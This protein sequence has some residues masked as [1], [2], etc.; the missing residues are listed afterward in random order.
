MADILVL[1]ER[2]KNSIQLG[3]SHIREFKSAWQGRPDDKKK[4]DVK[5]LCWYIGEALVAFANADGGVL[6]IGVEDDGVITG[7]PHTEAE[8][9]CFLN[10]TKTH[11]HKDTPIP[12]SNA[13]KVEIDGKKVLFFSVSKGTTTVCQLPDGRCVQRN[14]KATIPASF[15]QITFERQE[16]K[17][18]NYDRE[19]IDGATVNDLDLSLLQPIASSYIK[20]IS[21][22]RYLQQIGLAE[23]GENLRLRMAA[24]L[25]FAK[26]VQKWHPR[27][28]IRILRISGTELKSGT[29]YNV[30]SDETVLGNIFQLIE[31]SWERLRP[32]LASKVIFD[33]E[34]KFEQ[35]FIYPEDACKEALINAITHRDYSIQNGIDI[36]IFTDRIEIKNPGAL[37]SNLTIKG[38]EELQGLHESRNV[39]I[40]MVLRENKY[41][42]ELGEGMKRMFTLMQQSELQKPKLYSNTTW[43]SITFYRK[44]SFSQVEEQ[45]LSIFDSYNLTP[46]Q[47][48]LVVLGIKGREICPSE[49]FKVLGTEDLLIYGEEVKIL[50]NAGIF[51]EIRTNPQALQY[52]KRN[53]IPKRQVPRFKVRIPKGN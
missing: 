18:R 26:N 17:S 23:Y 39:Y 30:I 19:F 53:K 13:A 25:L 38:L 41:V 4:G 47:K 12:L 34:A 48:R 14:D 1:Q 24:L 51:E 49:I 7:I 29:E 20:G 10:A 44:S 21:I 52:S 31:N 9:E 27:S 35:K 40:A 46:N 11:I 37:L 5:A 15:S 8:I 42:R 33:E 36:F 50:R 45:W 3:E 28:Q 43:F 32:F 16:Q 2:V 6:L 22:E